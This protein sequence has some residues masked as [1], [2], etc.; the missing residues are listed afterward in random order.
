MRVIPEACRGGGEDWGGV[1]QDPETGEVAPLVRT[2]KPDTTTGLPAGSSGTGQCRPFEVG[3]VLSAPIER[4]MRATRV[5]EFELPHVGGKY[6]RDRRS[7]TSQ[8]PDRISAAAMCVPLIALYGREHVSQLSVLI[9]YEL[10]A[11]TRNR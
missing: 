11:Y 7:G 4:G 5:A 10:L 3:R 9:E 2:S 1:V 8:P 6:C